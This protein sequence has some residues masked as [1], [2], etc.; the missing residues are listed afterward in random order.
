MFIDS[1]L[2]NVYITFTEKKCANGIDC[3][4]RMLGNLIM[5]HTLRHA[6]SPLT[7]SITGHLLLP[8]IS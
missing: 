3:L 8:I 7:T 6:D 5:L 1:I 2:C 4:P